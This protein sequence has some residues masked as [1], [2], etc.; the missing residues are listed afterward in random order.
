MIY[1]RGNLG[2]FYKISNSGD[3]TRISRET[4]L[5]AISK[6]KSIDDKPIKHKN[7][8][9]ACDK[10]LKEKIKKNMKEYEMGKYVSRAQA[11]AVSYSQMM[12]KYSSCKKYYRK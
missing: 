12:K 2:Y 8:E 3:K 10:Y 9:L 4:Y 6:T 7:N 11:L 1:K 5:K